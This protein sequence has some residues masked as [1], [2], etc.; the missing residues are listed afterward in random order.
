[1][2]LETE[3]DGTGSILVDDDLIAFSHQFTVTSG[4]KQA[5]VEDMMEGIVRNGLSETIPAQ[6][7]VTAQ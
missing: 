6:S 4:E 1:L 2:P 3:E 5:T 7:E